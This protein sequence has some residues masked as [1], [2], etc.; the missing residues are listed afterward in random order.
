MQ[1]FSLFVWGEEKMNTNK[2]K[3]E[4]KIPLRLNILFFIV[5]IL[6]SILIIQLGIVQILHGASFQEEIDRTIVDASKSPVPRG[7]IFD[8][9]G[10]LIVDNKPLYAI[11]YTP[12]KRVQAKDKLELAEDLSP[13]LALDHKT[14]DKLTERNKQEYI[15]LKN[16]KAIMKRL[17]ESELELDNAKQYRVALEKVTDEEINALTEEELKVIAIKRELDKAYALTPEVI[18]NDNISIEEYAKIAEHLSELSGINAT[19]D[20]E[21][22]YKYGD[23]LKSIIGSITTQEQGIP[24]EQED[25]YLTRGYNRNDRV[26]KSGLEEQYEDVL[27]GRKEQIEYTTTKQGKIVGSEIKVEGERGKDLILAL[28]MDYQPIVDDIVMGELRKSVGS[29]YYLEDALAV[30]MNP[31][32][33]E[34]LALSGA[35]YNRENNE[36]EQAPHKIFYD[37]HRPGSTV[38]GATVLTGLQSGVIS[39]G[40]VFYDAPVKVKGTP[41]KASYARLGAVDDIR[42]LKVSSNVYMYYIGLRMGGE[43]R[44]PFPTNGTPTYNRQ[45]AQEMRNYFH[46]FGLGVKT[47]VDFPF[48]STGFVG[49]ARL[50]GNLMDL[51]IGQYDT[52]TALQMVQYVSTIANGGYRVEPHLVKEIRYPSIGEELGAVYKVNHPKMLNQIDVNPDYIKR[53]QNGFWKVFNEA[54]GTGYRY[55]AGKSY[56]AAGKTGTAE[57]E[58]FRPGQDGVYRKVADTENLTLVGYAPFDNPEVAFAVI[59]PNLSKRTGGDVN[60]RIGTKLLD[61]YF[62]LKANRGKQADDELED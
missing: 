27:R 35:H 54:G 50:P 46:Q 60:H 1:I 42:A 62:D 10:K 52:Y 32:T 25:F 45:G 41:V 17:S 9:N 14:I 24:A 19:T 29:N 44:H 57:N 56:R 39:P 43:F 33:G 21:R 8:R 15:Y 47:G 2:K 4:T 18:K 37:A 59:V 61:A 13:F 53:V 22:T 11:S 5:F 12:P 3:E 40:T 7:K 28:D 30:V 34:I 6:F 36:F 38:K 20:W 58:V 31:N 23:T 55:W 48:E 26:G 16:K 51:G 49:D